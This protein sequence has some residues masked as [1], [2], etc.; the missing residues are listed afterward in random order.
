MTKF[1]CGVVELNLSHTGLGAR[2]VSHLAKTLQS[3][4]STFSTLRQ[5]DLSFNSVKGEEIGVSTL[6][7]AVNKKEIIECS[8]ICIFCSPHLGFLRPC[9]D[10]VHSF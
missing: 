6:S 1:S 10:T 3:M 9:C 8:D 4:P 5:L 7:I 2:G